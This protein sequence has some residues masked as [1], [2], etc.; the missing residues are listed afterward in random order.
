MAPHYKKF[1]LQYLN[2]QRKEINMVH[3]LAGDYDGNVGI[4]YNDEYIHLMELF[5]HGRPVIDPILLNEGD[6]VTYSDKYNDVRIGCIG[7]IDH[8]IGRNCNVHIL[9]DRVRKIID[10][11]D[12]QRV[13]WYSPHRTRSVNIYRDERWA[14]SMLYQSDGKYIIGDFNILVQACLAKLNYEIRTTFNLHKAVEL[15]NKTQDGLI[16]SVSDETGHTVYRVVRKRFM[17]WV[18]KNY[19][20]FMRSPIY[21]IRYVEALQKTYVTEYD[22]LNNQ[23][24]HCKQ[25]YGDFLEMI[26]CP[27]DERDQYYE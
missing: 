1:I 17:K 24:P 26:T 2:V 3:T 23:C 4:P 21:D 11:E 13:I 19:T 18:S 9:K 6:I 15:Y 12:V 16:G 25:Q 27:C 10:G 22:N 14:I 8:F 7:R 5:G 20:K